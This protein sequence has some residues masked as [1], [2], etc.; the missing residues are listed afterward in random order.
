VSNLG[1]KRV[2]WVGV[3]KQG[4]DR[5]QNLVVY[6]KETAVSTVTGASM[7]QT[8]YVLHENAL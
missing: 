4:A 5:K 8:S 7:V 1:D 3:R 2:I 6:T